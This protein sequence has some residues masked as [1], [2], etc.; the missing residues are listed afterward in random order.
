MDQHPDSDAVIFGGI[1]DNG[2]LQF[3]NNSA[4]YHSDWGDGGFCGY[5]SE[6]NQ[7]MIVHQ[8]TRA[9]LL[10]SEKAGNRE[11]WD[12]SISQAL[13]QQRPDTPLFLCASYT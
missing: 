11:S 4:F 13:A 3:R 7:I 2:T 9:G 10:S 8:R 6:R 5:K 12:G 1:Q